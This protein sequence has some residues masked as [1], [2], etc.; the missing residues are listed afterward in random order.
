MTELICLEYNI[1]TQYHKISM[2]E[3]EQTLRSQDGISV[4]MAVDFA[5]QLMIF[6]ECGN[7][8]AWEEL[9]QAREVCY[10]IDLRIGQQS[11]NR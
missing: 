10:L 5:E 4:E 6:E 3:F 9:I 2:N 1:P 11:T 7:I 8:Y